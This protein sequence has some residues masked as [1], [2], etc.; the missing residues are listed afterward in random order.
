MGDVPDTGE[1]EYT[2][3]SEVDP[4]FVKCEWISMA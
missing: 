1:S 4:S 2:G 3:A